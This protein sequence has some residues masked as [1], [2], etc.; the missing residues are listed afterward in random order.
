MKTDRVLSVAECLNEWGAVPT[1]VEPP[2]CGA[3]HVPITADMKPGPRT[4]ARSC[5]CDR[6]G[7]PCPGCDERDVQP[8]AALS[9]SSLG[10]QTR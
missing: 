8:K 7:H 2:A 1:R 4:N 6:W 10:K 5:N 9:I 3:R